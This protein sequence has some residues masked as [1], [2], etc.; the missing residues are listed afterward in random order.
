M[1]LSIKSPRVKSAVRE[2]VEAVMELNMAG[3]DLPTDVATLQRE[4]SNHRFRVED[5]RKQLDMRDICNNNLRE[6]INR[7]ESELAAERKRVA[8]L[9]QD[10]MATTDFSLTKAELEKINANVVGET[11]HLP[12]T[13]DDFR[14]ESN[15]QARTAHITMGGFIR[16]IKQEAEQLN[17]VTLFA[18]DAPSVIISLADRIQQYLDALE[19]N[20]K[21]WENR[22]APK[23]K[24]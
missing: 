10:N 13:D 6:T 21:R 4:L 23:D 5:L 14:V 22:F 9:L 11:R 16:K 20:R 19:E 18:Y 24:S 15:I 7:L 2:L 12:Q 1:K 17:E 3:Q 8:E